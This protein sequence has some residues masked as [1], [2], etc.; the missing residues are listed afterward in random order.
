MK[1]TEIYEKTTAAL[2]SQLETA[3]GNWTAPWHSKGFLPHNATTQKAYQGGNV[4]ILWG[5]QLTLGYAT[6]VWAT[7]KQWESIGAQVRKGEKGTG[8]VKWSPVIDKRDPTGER[9]V[10]VP[11]GFTVFNAA[12]VD[13][14]V[15]PAET[16]IDL[17]AQ[18][19]HVEEF[20]AAQGAIVLQG[21]PAYAPA[22][23]TIFL[24][25]V[26]DFY[27]HLGFYAVTAHEYGHWTGNAKRLDRKQSG[28]Q[29]SPEYAFE[30]LIAEISASFTAAFLGFETEPRPDHANYIKH[31]AALL[32]DDPQAIFKA[33]SAAQKATNFLI[34]KAS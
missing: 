29:N 21:E 30:E 8:L 9:T 13:G 34:E 3:D 32:R 27:D 12:Q 14:Y 31:W 11:S 15:P 5:T 25:P 2:L 4:L 1:A 17:S 19:D 18:L 23:D 7:Y 16:T 33:A 22:L 24:P 26:S 10:L 28:D 6:P 20:F